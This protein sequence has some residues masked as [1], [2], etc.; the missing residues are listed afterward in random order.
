LPSRSI[1]ARAVCRPGRRLPRQT[2]LA[3]IS[4]KAVT[5]VAP[6]RPRRILLCLFSPCRLHGQDRLLLYGRNDTT[7]D[8]AAGCDVNLHGDPYAPGPIPRRTFSS[9]AAKQ[10]PRPYG[11]MEPSPD[12]GEESYRGSGRL[13]GEAAI[14]TGGHSGIGR[15]VAIAFAREARMYSSPIWTKTTMP[16]K[17]HAGSKRPVGAPC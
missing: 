12:H 7:R 16:A 11:P 9:A 17:Q 8:L 5:A 6:A 10:R 15:A 2:V 4:G 13:A 1:R 3:A 14:V